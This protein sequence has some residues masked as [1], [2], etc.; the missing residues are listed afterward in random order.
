MLGGYK[1]NCFELPRPARLHCRPDLVRVT[2]YV[3]DFFL[4]ACVRF[5]NGEERLDHSPCGGF[6]APYYLLCKEE[7]NTMK[8]I[9]VLAVVALTEDLPNLNLTRGQIGTVLE[10]LERDGEPALLVEFSDEHGEA[11]AIAPVRPDRLIALHRKREA[12]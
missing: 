6:P 4:D 10:H 8:R 1:I 11:Y 2:F 3:L 7:W 9:P 5:R 12:A